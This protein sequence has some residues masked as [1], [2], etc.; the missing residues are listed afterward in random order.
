[1]PKEYILGATIS[2]EEI[3]MILEA[4]NWAPTHQKM[5][6]WRYSIIKGTFPRHI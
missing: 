3:D 5:E 1:M 4:A 6:P 2:D